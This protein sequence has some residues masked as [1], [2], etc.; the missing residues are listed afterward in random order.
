DRRRCVFVP[1]LARLETAP[2]FPHL[3][4]YRPGLALVS[5]PGDAEMPLGSNDS[6]YLV[7]SLLDARGRLSRPRVAGVAI[8]AALPTAGR[9]PSDRGAERQ[10]LYGRWDE[11]QR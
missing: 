1:C 7:I 5:P 6:L 4:R 11:N 10:L 3:D 9:H 8:S 2:D